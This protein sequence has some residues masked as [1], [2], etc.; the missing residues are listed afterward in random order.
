MGLDGYL[1]LRMKSFSLLRSRCL[2]SSRNELTP[3]PKR[4]LHNENNK[5]QLEILRISTQD[6]FRQLTITEYGKIIITTVTAIVVVVV[7]V[8][9]IVK[10]NMA[11]TCCC[12]VN[13]RV[14]TMVSKPVVHVIVASLRGFAS[15]VSH[16]FL[17]QST[18]APRIFLPLHKFYLVRLLCSYHTNVTVTKGLKYTVFFK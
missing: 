8:P 14:M 1:Q 12:N 7:E 13:L 5:K 9:Q 17:A 15:K 18:L 6:G 2:S 10:I 3:S 4:R 16:L 11:K